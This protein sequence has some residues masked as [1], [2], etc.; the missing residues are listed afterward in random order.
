MASISPIR[1]LWSEF[2]GGHYEL[3][4]KKPSPDNE[5]EEYVTMRRKTKAPEMTVAQPGIVCRN[6]FTPLQKLLEHDEDETRKGTKAKEKKK[7]SFT[8]L[9]EK[10]EGNGHEHSPKRKAMSPSQKARLAKWKARRESKMDMDQADILNQAVKAG[11]D[12]VTG[13]F[14]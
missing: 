6:R 10:K 1:L 3:L 2:G 7:T 9:A 8:I 13:V 4:T 11:E 12:L 14:E 5:R